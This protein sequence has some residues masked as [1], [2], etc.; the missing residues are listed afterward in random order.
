MT[1]SNH[2]TEKTAFRSNG[3]EGMILGGHLRDVHPGRETETF[4]IRCPK[5]A[6]HNPSIRVCKAYL[7]SAQV[8]ITSSYE[9][10]FFLHKNWA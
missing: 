7:H 2:A 4:K 1:G 6:H 5:S 9:T 10:V 8:E 3:R